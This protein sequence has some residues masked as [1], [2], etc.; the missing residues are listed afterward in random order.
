MWIGVDQLD[1]APEMVFQKAHID[2]HYPGG[3]TGWNSR[4]G[5]CSG[6]LFTK[7]LVLF[8]RAPGFC[9]GL[10]NIQSVYDISWSTAHSSLQWFT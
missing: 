9:I 7:L 6:T 5:C 1:R 4:R 3:G 2:N 10:D 8:C